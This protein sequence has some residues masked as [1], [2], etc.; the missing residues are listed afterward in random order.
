MGRIFA[1]FGVKG[2]VKVQPDTAAVRNL[3]DYREWWVRRDG[4]WRE[5]AVTDAKAQGRVV[6]AKLEGCEDRDAAAKLRGAPVAVPRAALPATR[7]GEYYWTDLIGLKV[8]NADGQDFGVVT[9]IL[10]TGANDVLVVD[11]ERERLIPF[12]A[13]VV[14]EVDP[15][16]GV[17][18]VE[19]HADY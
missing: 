15:A 3:L 19:W 18:R 8:V 12:I 4:E 17:V 9:G 5:W 7:S 2:W 6:L 10:P 11:G 16:S 1:P 14:L 13:T